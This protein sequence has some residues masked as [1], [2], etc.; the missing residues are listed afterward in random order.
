MTD[1]DLRKMKRKELLELLIV[2]EK[3]N[4]RLKER[5]NEQADEFREKSLTLGN[6]GSLAEAALAL[7]GIF[8]SADKTAAQYVE[9]IK[10]CSEEQQSAYDRIVSEAE[11]KAKEILD[12]AERE[13]RAKLKAADEYRQS[14]NDRIEELY[15][16]NPELREL[17]PV[18]E[19]KGQSE[20]NEKE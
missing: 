5:L 20:V 15:R 9:A 2:L 18:Q 13:S 17:L 14:I 1:H 6:F 16:N 19:F 3:D 10:R 4:G 12:E 7:N 8:E 11:Q